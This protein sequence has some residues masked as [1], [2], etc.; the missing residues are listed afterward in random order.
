MSPYSNMSLMDALNDYDNQFPLNDK[1]RITFDFLMMYMA[2]F[3]ASTLS[4]SLLFHACSNAQPKQQPPPNPGSWHAVGLYDLRKPQSLTKVERDAAANHDSTNAVL[5]EKTHPS[6][7]HSWR[8]S[9][10]GYTWFYPTRTAVIR[11]GRTDNGDFLMNPA[12][13]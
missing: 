5:Y 8:Y 10:D 2:F 1:A 13:D 6:G 11:R 7:T 4:V 3:L 9:L 12:E